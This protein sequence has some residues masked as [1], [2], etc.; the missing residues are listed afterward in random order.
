MPIYVE[1]T[2]P[3]N[4]LYDDDDD[5]DILIFQLWKYLALKM[6]ADWKYSC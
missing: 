4:E 1:G 2:K 6:Y 3:L 5:D